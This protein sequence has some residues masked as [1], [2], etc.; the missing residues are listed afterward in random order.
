MLTCKK[1]WEKHLPAKIF[2]FTGP[3]ILSNKL[4]VFKVISCTG[5]EVPE[6][7]QVKI[8]PRFYHAV[9]TFYYYIIQHFLS[10]SK[11]NKQF[12][13][14]KM[15]ISWLLARITKYILKRV[16][17]KLTFFGSADEEVYCIN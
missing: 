10:E 13:V 14:N 12:S 3:S 17:Q 5:Q 15:E 8:L 16:E 2:V 7:Y 6:A 11:F 1:G 9:P 4:C